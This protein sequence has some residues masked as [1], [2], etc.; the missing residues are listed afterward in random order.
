M[1]DVRE[2]PKRGIVEGTDVSVLPLLALGD[3]HHVYVRVAPF[4]MRA[5]ESEQGWMCGWEWGINCAGGSLSLGFL[6]WTCMWA[7]NP[8]L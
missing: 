6:G 5:S 2:G 8:Q 4:Q 1:N 7:G 3:L